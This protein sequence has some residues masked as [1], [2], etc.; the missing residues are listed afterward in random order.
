MKLMQKHSIKQLHQ[1]MINSLQIGIYLSGIPKYSPEY[2]FS[3]VKGASRFV[4]L[5]LLEY[6]FVC[7]YDMVVT[8]DELMRLIPTFSKIKNLKKYACIYV[9]GSTDGYKWQLL[10]RNERNGEF[11]DIGCLVERVDC[12]YFRIVFCGELNNQS[13]MEYIELQGSGTIFN[14]KMR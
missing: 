4:D 14:E 6:L 9:Y 13:F 5:Q 11:V 8:Y 12:K 1:F 10:G 7:P 3:L 2:T